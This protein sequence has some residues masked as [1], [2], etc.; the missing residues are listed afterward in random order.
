MAE[1]G[2]LL[3]GVTAVTPH[4]RYFMLH[5]AVAHAA[6]N[7]GLVAA[8]AR[9]LLRRSEVVMAAISLT[10]GDHPGMALA[11][12]GDRIRPFVEAGEVDVA[13]LVQP[14]GYAQ[15]SW[16]FLG[17][18]R[19]S[20][21]LLGLVRWE[22]DSLAP[23]P[24][25][26]ASA[27]ADLIPL[28]EL[29]A[30][31]V[32]DVETLRANQELCLCRGPSSFDGGHFRGLF[33]PRGAD[34]KSFAGR[35]G[36]TVKLLLRI[37]Q[38]RPINAMTA[39]LWPIIAYDREVAEDTTCRRVADEVSDAWR[40][41]ILRNQSVNAWRQL[42][43]QLTGLIG[44]FTTLDELGNSFA[45]ALPSSTVG[46]YRAALPDVSDRGHPLAAERDESVTNRDLPDRNL[47]LLMLGAARVGSLSE[48]IEAY[49]QP[50]S[51]EGNE[52]TPS[53]LAARAREWDTRSLR[54]FARWLTEV[55]VIRS[56]RIAIRK[57]QFSSKT[58]AFR[59]PGRVFVRDDR[60]FRD[61]GEPGLPIGYRWGALSSVL[62][63]AGLVSFTP[64][65]DQKRP[66]WRPTDLGEAALS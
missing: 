18:Y 64:D 14:G 15:A 48:R 53:W 65:H 27:V 43:S 45:D 19:S 58:G 3:P 32:I 46:D 38:L 12:G 7:R 61:S 20:E 2:R 13:R 21:E 22:N 17:P 44:S 29:A 57:A 47:A 56:Q 25:A 41:V 30:R 55:M 33:I 10:H 40:G 66:T 51:E 5:A 4:A 63:T 28:L 8:E 16:G 1:V 36:A 26:P 39:D 54:D 9:D 62:A 35:R 52:L 24:A 59:I 6:A 60:I 11:H 50:S 42:W 31:D 34:P 37:F 23:G 49:F